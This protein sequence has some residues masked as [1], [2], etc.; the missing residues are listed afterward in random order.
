MRLLSL[1]PHS[2]WE[3]LHLESFFCSEAAHMPSPSISFWR[4]QFVNHYN[5]TQLQWNP[6]LLLFPP[7]RNTVS[8]FNV[9]A[10]EYDLRYVEPGEQTLTIETIIIHPHFSTKKP[11]DYDIALLKMAGAF[12]FGKHLK[13][14]LNCPPHVLQNFCSIAQLLK[15]KLCSMCPKFLDHG[16]WDRKSRWSSPT[17]NSFCLWL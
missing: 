10:G 14:T 6:S 5:C 16:L 12:R 1:V 3:P 8:T 13:F 11:M 15:Y 7:H 4:G 9:T 17:W 2:H